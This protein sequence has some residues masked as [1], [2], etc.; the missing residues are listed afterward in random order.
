MCEFCSDANEL[1]KPQGYKKPVM[2]NRSLGYCGKLQ[3]NQVMEISD[4]NMTVKVKGGCMTKPYDQFV[5]IDNLEG[6]EVYTSNY[7]ID[8]R[9]HYKQN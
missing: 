6:R 4:V 8:E 1:C 3:A 7:F 5:K 2:S 9:T